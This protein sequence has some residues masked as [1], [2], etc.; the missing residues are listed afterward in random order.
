M[1]PEVTYDMDYYVF[2]QEIIWLAV[3]VHNRNFWKQ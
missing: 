1:N 2:E 3:N